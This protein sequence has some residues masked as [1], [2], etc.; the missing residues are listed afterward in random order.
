MLS[1]LVVASSF[2]GMLWV[3]QQSNCGAIEHTLVVAAA[4]M[5]DA[6]QSSSGLSFWSIKHLLLE[7]LSK[8]IDI[9]LLLMFSGIDLQ[10]LVHRSQR[11][12]R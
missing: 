12:S 6:P 10:L 4:G 1:Q 11:I 5:H 7:G 8:E 3:M 2:G 9:L